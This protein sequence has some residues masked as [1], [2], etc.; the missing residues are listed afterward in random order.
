MLG[1]GVDIVELARI[2]AALERQGLALAQRVLTEAEFAQFQQSNYPSRLL[3]KRFAAKEAVSKALGTGIAKGV[4]F[5]GIE[6][7]HDS[8]GAPVVRLQDGALA[9][10]HALGGSKC[11]VSISDERHYV[12]ACAILA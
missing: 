1:M 11:W 6:I 8:L 12:V 5:Q 3:A 9:R 10:L 7:A 4:G 2:E